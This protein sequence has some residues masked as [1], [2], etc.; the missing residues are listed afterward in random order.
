[1]VYNFE[2]SK[3]T[4]LEKSD[5]SSIGGWDAP[6][7]NLCNLINKTDNYYTTSS[8]SG[9]VVLIIETFE[10]RSGLFLYRSHDL[11][12][13]DELK[14]E[15]EKVRSKTKDLIYFKQ[16][17]C[18]LAVACAS[19]SDAQEL[20]N[21]ARM[22]GWKRSGITTTTKK[23]IVELFGTEKIEMP[24]LNNGEILV[25]DDFLR[26]LIEQTNERIKRTWSKI[27]SFCKEL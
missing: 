10:K 14:K 11:V 1:M 12:S 21:K 20:V 2:N 3:K 9:R 22:A 17:P 26:L 4:I 23:N 16:E 27:D 24:I 18:V 5:K 8:C 7:A 19:V 25:S 13:F 15:L 6:I